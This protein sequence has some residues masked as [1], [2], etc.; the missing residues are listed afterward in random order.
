MTVSITG[1]IAVSYNIDQENSKVDFSINCTAGE[2]PSDIVATISCGDAEP[3][4]VVLHY[5]YAPVTKGFNVTG[6]TTN[7]IVAS[8]DTYKYKDIVRQTP[9]YYSFSD[10]VATLDKDSDKFD[11]NVVQAQT[12]S[13]T[14]GKITARVNIKQLAP[15]DEVMHTLTFSCGE[16]D[17]QSITVRAKTE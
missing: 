8:Y 5:A 10:V 15:C 17:T 7:P 6:G 16:A 12:V 14:T 9:P 13:T 4:D 2:P 11:I 3:V 1:D